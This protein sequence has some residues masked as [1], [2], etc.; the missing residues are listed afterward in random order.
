MVEQFGYLSLFSVVWPL[1]GVSF[2]INNWIELR[3]DAVK[4]CIEMRRPVPQ[5]AESIGTWLD[6]LSFLSWVGSISSAAIVYLFSNDGQGPD[7]TPHTIQGWALLL[8]IFFSEHIYLA[9]RWVVNTSIAKLD[10]PGKQKERRERYTVRRKYFEDSLSR[11]REAPTLRNSA[12]A[13]VGEGFNRT[14]LE[15]EARQASTTNA[16]LQDRF[17]LRQRNWRESLQV[18]IQMIDDITAKGRE[19]RKVQ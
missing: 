5:R 13:G 6:N 14:S 1:T 10:S 11:Q 7:G 9:V 16:S 8:S 15:E 12:A 2:L 18:G 19:G 4:I 17:W 3:A